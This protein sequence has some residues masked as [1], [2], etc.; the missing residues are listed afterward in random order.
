MHNATPAPAHPFRPAI[1]PFVPK[2]APG[3]QGNIMSVTGVDRGLVTLHH[4]RPSRA[5]LAARPRPPSASSRPRMRRLRRHA[6]VVP[7]ARK[8]GRAA[9][10]APHAPLAAPCGSRAAGAQARSCR[11]HGPA[12]AC[13]ACGATAGV[14]PQAR[15]QG[16]AA[17]TAPHAPLAAP[18]GSRAAGQQGRAA[19]AQ[20]RMVRDPR[21]LRQTLSE[22]PPLILSFSPLPP[23]PVLHGER[24]GVRGSGK[25][26][27]PKHR[28]PRDPYGPE[29]MQSDGRGC[30]S[31]T[32]GRNVRPRRP[33][34]LP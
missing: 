8:Q 11:R 15:K 33:G 3:K 18:C 1:L 24:V 26:R 16:R 12:T 28:P 32:A 10:T 30:R 6:E 9:G 20:A 7:Q 14:V 31:A 13:A 22:R 29:G 21:A 2:L 19:G 34:G 4:S 17:G 5:S 27:P 25:L 23:L